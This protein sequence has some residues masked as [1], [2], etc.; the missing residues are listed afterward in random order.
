M[1]PVVI[2]ANSDGKN[3]S[4]HT[5]TSTHSSQNRRKRNNESPKVSPTIKR[6]V[7]DMQGGKDDIHSFKRTTELNRSRENAMNSLNSS[8]SPNISSNILK[9]D[10]SSIINSSP[11]AGSLP[12]KNAHNTNK[13][14]PTSTS[15]QIMNQSNDKTIINLIDDDNDD[16]FDNS[17]IF[18]NDIKN[19]DKT[20]I[21]SQLNQFHRHYNI[22]ENP[23]ICSQYIRMER[24]MVEIN[25]ENLNDYEEEIHILESTQYRRDFLMAF[26][27]CEK[28]ISNLNPNIPNEIVDELDELDGIKSLNWDDEA[29]NS[30]NRTLHKPLNKNTPKIVQ[31]ST[32]AQL[33]KDNNTNELNNRRKKFNLAP[34]S[35]ASFRDAGPF[36]GLPLF[37]KQLIKEY[38]GIDG[39]YDWQDECLNLDAIPK[40]ENLIYALP[41]S[42]GK[43]LVAEIIILREIICRKR[44]VLF[45][46]PFVSIVQE[47]V[48]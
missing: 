40:R 41:T 8:F 44:N 26:D 19:L 48:Y 33:L 6:I 46:L 10:S 38:K 45:I 43:T 37:V 20:I 34:V 9:N 24:S 18:L 47:K 32:S 21:K 23:E 11:K 16:L 39:M 14:S 7:L 29:F 27:E 25:E 12:F 15:N 4:W 28:S 13:E 1:K 2:S 35:T 3:N 22:T 36:Y 17:Q 30:P 31:P 42:G 5:P